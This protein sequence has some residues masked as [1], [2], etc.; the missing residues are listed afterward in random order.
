MQIND[1]VNLFRVPLYLY[2]V[3]FLIVR[4]PGCSQDERVKT[5]PRFVEVELFSSQHSLM[6]PGLRAAKVIQC[7]W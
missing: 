1:H 5:L 7:T 4:P 2:N 6:V 3:F